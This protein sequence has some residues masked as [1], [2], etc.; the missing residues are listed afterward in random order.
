MCMNL[1]NYIL[2]KIKEF[3]RPLAFAFIYLLFGTL[4]ILITDKIVLKYTQTIDLIE[5]FQ[6]YKG[7]FFIIITTILLFVIVYYDTR[8]VKKTLEK[9]EESEQKFKKLFNEAMDMV[10]VTDAESGIILDCNK[11]A[12]IIIGKRKEI[13]VGTPEKF[14]HVESEHVGRFS[15]SYFEHLFIDSTKRLESKIIDAHGKVTDVSIKASEIRINNR[16]LIQSVYRDISERKQA[17]KKLKISEA[18]FRA[19][20]ENMSSAVIIFKTYTNKKELSIIDMNSYAEKV[21]DERK[22]KVIGKN[23]DEVFPYLKESGIVDI[24]LKVAE[25]GNSEHHPALRYNLEYESRYFDSYA[26]KLSDSEIVAIFED[27]TESIEAEQ[28]KTKYINDRNKLIKEKQLQF[29]RMPI[30]LVIC[31]KNLDIIDLNPEAEK[32]FGFRKDEVI[33]KTFGIFFQE[34]DNLILKETIIDIS[35]SDDTKI[36]FK[37]NITKNGALILCEWHKTPL[38]DEDGQF[39]GLMAMVKD[40]TEEKQKEKEILKLTLAVEQSPSVVIL[41]DK[42]ANITYVNKRFTE[43]T[44]Y[45]QEEV[46]G[47]NPRFLQSGKMKKADYEYMWKIISSGELWSGNFLNKKK[48]GELYWENARIFSIKDEK[49]EILNF[50]AVKEDISEL[51]KIHDSLEESEI[52]YRTMFEFSSATMLLI[53][54]KDGRI[55]DVNQTAENYYGYSKEQLRRM[56]ITDINITVPNNKL[57]SFV[58]IVRSGVKKYF[59]FKHKL[60]NGDVRDVEV[61]PSVIFL[62]GKEL[63]FSIIHDITERKQAEDELENY[64]LHL[65]DLVEERTLELKQTEERFRTIAEN[66]Q[67]SITRFNDK[68]QV[69]YVN[70]IIEERVGFKPDKLLG[71]TPSEII[72]DSDLAALLINKLKLVF[73]DK[74]EGRIEFEL[75]NKKWIEWLLLPEYDFD[76]NIE[77]VI[78]FGRDITQR[79]K[80]EETIMQALETERELNELKNNFISTASHEF[81]TPLSAVLSSAELL[82]RYGKKWNEEKYNEHILRIRNSV[83]YLTN[84]MDDILNVSRIETGKLEFNLTQVALEILCMNL[85]DEVKHSVKWKGSILLKYLLKEKYYNLDEKLIRF[86][87][88]NL[89]SNAVKYSLD[90]NNIEMI[91]ELIENSIKFTIKDNGIGIPL[92]DQKMIFEPFHRAKNVNDIPGTGLGMFIVKKSVEM[93]KGK[94]EI[95]SIQGIG[96]T[97]TVIIPL[98]Y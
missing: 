8:N 40:I 61:Y 60:A 5:I 53:D 72:P 64:K 27:V 70:P 90:S 78:V 73:T 30:G 31:D 23:I 32:I 71:K 63:L 14:L 3:S 57:D 59:H 47:K 21:V 98:D 56:I 45:T 58:T 68:C 46:L 42:S 2:P 11:Q 96:T 65:E 44:G 97:I 92:E 17:E 88:S 51:K 95:Q 24:L 48:N 67:D 10:I 29:N 85:I 49:G 37:E 18:R 77:S 76:G 83:N 82:Q 6:Y 36:I 52:R 43:L 55:W 9:L 89:L 33:N 15:K 34:D 19:I 66:S 86:I 80:L 62:K 13:L 7:Q 50:I 20:Y 12:E 94:I 69:I 39:I 81:R 35:K 4:W 26:T 16:K 79:K 54:P 91:V 41:T 87:L 28:A 84:L 93:H 25:T 1:K 22:E 38:K 74:K 75:P